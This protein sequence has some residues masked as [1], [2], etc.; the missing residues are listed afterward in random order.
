MATIS[1]QLRNFKEPDKDEQTAVFFAIPSD[2][3]P[4]LAASGSKEKAA[5]PVE[6][7]EKM[8]INAVLSLGVQGEEDA[9]VSRAFVCQVPRARADLRAAVGG[10]AAPP[11]ALSRLL[12]RG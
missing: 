12:E 11:A 3:A 4:A 8:D 1:A 6:G 7:L 5:A 10:Q 9:Y 2:P